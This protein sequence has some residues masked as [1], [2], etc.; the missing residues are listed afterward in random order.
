MGQTTPPNVREI[1]FITGA[2]VLMVWFA[3]LTAYK[4]GCSIR[5]QKGGQRGSSINLHA[6]VCL[7]KTDKNG[8]NGWLVIHREAKTFTK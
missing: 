3:P 6:V 2:F 4:D 8:C 5:C 1:F 7:A